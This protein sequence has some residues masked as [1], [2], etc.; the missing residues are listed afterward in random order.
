MNKTFLVVLYVSGS[1]HAQARL[2]ETYKFAICA[3][4]VVKQQQF[5]WILC[6]IL[7]LARHSVSKAKT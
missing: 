6:L 1:A 3:S 5:L 7:F 2:H 4:E